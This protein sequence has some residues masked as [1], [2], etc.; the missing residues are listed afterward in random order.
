MKAYVLH[1]NA[2][3]KD[4]A[5]STGVKQDCVLTPTLC[6]L[7]FAAMLEVAFR[8]TE[9]VACIKTRL[10]ANLFDMFHFEVKTKMKLY[11]YSKFSF[12]AMAL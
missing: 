4:F 7:Y 9:E 8:S 2:Q 5:V 1:G 12:L 11:L 3:S 6:L 10:L